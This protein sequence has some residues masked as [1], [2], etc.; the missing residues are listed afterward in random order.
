MNDENLSRDYSCDVGLAYLSVECLPYGVVVVDAAGQVLME[1]PAA[2]R[3]LGS[4]PREMSGQGLPLFGKAPVHRDGRP[5]QPGELPSFLALTA[6][7][8]SRG[9][10]IGSPRTEGGIA[11]R[12]VSAEPVAEDGRVVAAVLSFEEISGPPADGTSFRDDDG[13]FRLFMDNSPAIAWIKDETGRYAYLSKTFE[14]RFGVC[15]ADWHGKTDA[16][17]W[18]AEISKTFR[19]ND[20]AVLGS[21]HAI[22]VNE[23]SVGPDGSVC[24][25]RSSKFP[26]RDSA[27][28]R[29]VAGIGFEITDLVQAQTALVRQQESFR[30]AVESAP[31]AMLVADAGGVIV[32]AN[33]PLETLFGYEPGELLGQPVEMLVPEEVRSRHIAVRGDLVATPAVRRMGAGGH[34]VGRCKGGA[35]I[36]V[37]VGLSHTLNAD[38]A[39]KIIATVIDVSERDRQIIALRERE[40]R[41]RSVIET[42]P[43]GFWLASPEG[44]LMAVN[45]AYCRMSG[46]AREE[47]LE[48]SVSDLEAGEGPGGIGER[49]ARIMAEGHARFE[50]VHQRK[51]GGLFPVE[52][53]ASMIPEI[54]EISMFIRDITAIRAFEAEREQAAEM[55]RVMAY[56][57]P[58]TQLPNRRLLA[59]RLQLA[60]ATAERT[61]RHGGL[62]FI[63][64]DHFKE[65]NDSLGHE[66]GDLL[67]VQV[68]QRLTGCTREADTVARLGG[69]EFVIMLTELSESFGPAAAQVGVVAEK[70][71]GALNAPY[72]LRQH[73][74]RCSPSIGATAFLDEGD[75]DAIFRRADRAMYDVKKSGRNSIRFFSDG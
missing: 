3:I 10:V 8:S 45:S 13:R 51:G 47:L 34:L 46:Y 15:F 58:L 35:E 61:R 6:G 4:S 43:D 2:R 30:N 17:V 21:S 11:W 66:F 40:L 14:D 33:P 65:L 29:Y 71:L 37:E 56:H 5:F 50:T 12:S 68:A 16:D 63:D 9:V 1:N 41:Y 32:L 24:H 60:M 70:I 72:Q 53:T 57:D 23:E 19:E 26:F 36:P 22:M 27:G 52:I 42:T 18:P 44:R 55:I 31:I 73:T 64:L 67:L 59:D 25:W 74:Y 48:L 39:V 7:L 20:L 49:I 69:D 38:G 75:V 54:G 62:L 28:N